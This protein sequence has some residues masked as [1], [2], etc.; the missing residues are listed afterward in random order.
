MVNEAKVETY[1]GKVAG[2][3]NV[4]EVGEGRFKV[5]IRGTDKNWYG[6]F[7]NSETCENVKQD[8]LDAKIGKHTVVLEYTQ[9]GRWFNITDIVSFNLNGG[10]DQ[11]NL[12]GEKIIKK[13][14]DS[15]KYRVKQ[16][17]GCLEDAEKAYRDGLVAHKSL[18]DVDHRNIRAIAA[19][20]FIEENRRK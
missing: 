17:S 15:S 5:S 16:M 20:F 10:Q 4:S 9:Q 6:Y 2:V 8:A 19:C 3:S 13:T 7:D 18:T 14:G 1:K 12:K 11:E